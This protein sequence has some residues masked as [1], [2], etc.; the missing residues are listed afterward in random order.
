[1]LHAVR[2]IQRHYFFARAVAKLLDW[3]DLRAD[4]V[5]TLFMHTT[6]LVSH[7][8]AFLLSIEALSLQVLYSCTFPVFTSTVYFFRLLCVVPFKL[9][10]VPLISTAPSCFLHLYPL[11]PV[12]SLL[13]REK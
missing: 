11:S 13:S 1:M 10:T 12:G 2:L 9:G 5:W 3:V 8:V 6:I 7:V 4:L